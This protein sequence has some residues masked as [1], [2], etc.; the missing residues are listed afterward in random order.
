MGTVLMTKLKVKASPITIDIAIRIFIEDKSIP[1]LL[2]SIIAEFF[3]ED[4]IP[5]AM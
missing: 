5:N 2:I 4:I 3:H 1:T